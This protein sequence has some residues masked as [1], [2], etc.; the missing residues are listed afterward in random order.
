[1]K[2]N[3]KCFVLLII[4]SMFLLNVTNIDAYQ[5]WRTGVLNPLNITI[6]NTSSTSGYS[7]I[8]YYS[9]WTSTGVKFAIFNNGLSSDIVTSVVNQ[10]N[11]TYGVT[12]FEGIG[13]FRITYYKDFINTSLA[14]QRE[15][16]VHE[17]GHAL[18]LDHTQTINE[19]ISVMRARGF[20]NK[21]Y[22]LNDDILGIRAKYKL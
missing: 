15:T 3:R 7:A 20:N 21:A 16:V 2:K 9:K 1:M 11:G 8:S 22:P 13:K 6:Y 19:S 10:D 18:G 12:N 4:I 5:Y 17:V 14:W